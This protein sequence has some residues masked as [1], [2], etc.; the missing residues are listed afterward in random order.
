[1]NIPSDAWQ[2]IGAIFAAMV[3]GLVSFCVTVLA[4]EQKTSEFRQAW[5]DALRQELSDFAAVAIS[6]TDAIRL[7]LN[8]PNSKQRIQ[9]YLLKE[10]HSEVKELES[11]HVRIL[12]RL[13]PDEHKKF[14][15]LI[16]AAYKY[17]AARE[18]HGS[19]AG[20]KL[21]SDFIQ[22]SQQ[23]LKKEWRRVKRV[24]LFSFSQNGFPCFCLLV[25]APS[26]CYTQEG[27]F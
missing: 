12:L 13:N 27:I 18:A 25:A 1:M 10:R 2:V 9:D 5:I 19:T 21:I 14:I 11:L 24:N 16:E 23:V 20:E 22:A 6:L 15:Q 7:I 8:E 17:S 26:Q 3:A 4:K